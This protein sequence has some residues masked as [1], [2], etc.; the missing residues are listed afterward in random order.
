MIP[1]TEA[2]RQTQKQYSS[3]ALTLFIIVGACLLFSGYRSAGKG[4]ILGAVFSV[5]NFILMGIALPFQCGHAKGRTLLIALG[6]IGGRYLILAIPLI[7]AIKMEQFNL[8][9][10]VCGLFAIQL[11]MIADHIIR[12]TRDS[13]RK[14]K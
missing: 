4:L 8:Y 13:R 6:S 7:M 2:I 3:H 11:V 9:A 14:Q 5:F 10:V 1:G 12:Q